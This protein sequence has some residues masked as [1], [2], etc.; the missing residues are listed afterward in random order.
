MNLAEALSAGV[1]KE[2]AILIAGPD[3]IILEE[4]R[5]LDV[6]KKAARFAAANDQG[7]C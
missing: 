3:G 5:A 7:M 6:N 1:V 2:N 4:A